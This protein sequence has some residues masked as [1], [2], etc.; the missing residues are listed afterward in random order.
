ML[1]EEA[2]EAMLL[3]DE[4]ITARGLVRH[5]ADVFKHPTDITRPKDRR[6]VLERFQV[7]Q[8]ELRRVMAKADKNSK[9][10]LTA[11][12][13]RQEEE[14]AN[15]KHQRDLLVASHRAVILAVGE[16]G[17]M[18]NWR[19]F[20]DGYQSALDTMRDLGAL[21]ETE[22]SNPAPARFHRKD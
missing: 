9:V 4:D 8:E 16:L 1:M 11:R 10:N 6:G 19:R 7:R 15:L 3:N 22:I 13:V 21:P 17:G 2:L 20:F 5:M 14:I 12:I 18:R